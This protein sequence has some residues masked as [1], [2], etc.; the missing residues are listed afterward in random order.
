MENL[1]VS[2]TRV[3]GAP[4]S[5]G[6]LLDFHGDTFSSQ[7][8]FQAL[9]SID[10]KTI[11]TAFNPISTVQDFNQVHHYPNGIAHELSGESGGHRTQELLG[12]YQSL[13]NDMKS[14]MA[15][16]KGRIATGME[17]TNDNLNK[18]LQFTND[19]EDEES[20]EN[21][22]IS[23]GKNESVFSPLMKIQDNQSS[24]ISQTNLISSYSQHAQHQ[25]QPSMQSDHQQITLPQQNYRRI[26]EHHHSHDRQQESDLGRT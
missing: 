3:R 6:D 12:D 11:T 2:S 23:E 8:T 22:V 15:N 26:T 13:L 10:S 18:R 4:L 24:R 14:Q 5:Q 1:K 20:S 9:A 25:Q 17:Q 16:L 19:E 21:D 7:G